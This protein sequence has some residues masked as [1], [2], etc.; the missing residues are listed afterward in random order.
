MNRFRNII[1]QSSARSTSRRTGAPEA[2][3]RM[4][5][6][7]E[8]H[9]RA[10]GDL[11]LRRPLE[12]IDRRLRVS[13]QVF[14]ISSRVDEENRVVDAFAPA[15]NGVRRR[16]VA[17]ASAGRQPGEVPRRAMTKTTGSKEVAM[18]EGRRRTRR[19]QQQRGRGRA[20]KTQR[21]TLFR[22]DGLQVL[23]DKIDDINYK[24]VK[25]LGPSC[26]ARQDPRRI[27]GTAPVI[28]ETA[29][30]RSSGRDSSR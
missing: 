7:K 14:A 26:P 30:A 10:R 2:R 23:R 28:S 22:A 3:P 4:G 8:R 25:L 6:H 18:R 27:S 21:R 15:Q 12:G 20:E 11:G 17:A 19:Q 13:D 1:G 9:L 29:R 5:P 24:D 16:R